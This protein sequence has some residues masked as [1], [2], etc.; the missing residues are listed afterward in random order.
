MVYNSL[1]KKRGIYK[2]KHARW[3]RHEAGCK[4]CSKQ[5]YWCLN[6]FTNN[7]VSVQYNNF[8]DFHAVPTI[9]D[10]NFHKR[11]HEI[12]LMSAVNLIHFLRVIS[13]ICLQ[14]CLIYG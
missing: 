6:M 5:N 8:L 12:I 1:E 13:L 3:Y 2:A 4:N 9:R 11:I 10:N 7:R 14:R